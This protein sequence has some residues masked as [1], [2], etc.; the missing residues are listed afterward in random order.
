MPKHQPHHKPSYATRR[1]TEKVQTSLDEL[2][3]HDLYKLQQGVLHNSLTPCDQKALLTLLQNLCQLAEAEAQQKGCSVQQT[4]L[5]PHL[6]A[7]DFSAWTHKLNQR[8]LF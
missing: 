8:A 3:G 1:A 7:G 4:E 6:K 2:K 5:F